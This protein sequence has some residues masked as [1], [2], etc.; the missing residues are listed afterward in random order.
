MIF[1]TL[2]LSLKSDRR[3]GFLQY[4]SLSYT[5][6]FPDITWSLAC[7]FLLPTDIVEHSHNKLHILIKVVL[8]GDYIWFILH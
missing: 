8:N 6:K 4:K 7:N 1:L 2:I 5:E 3:V